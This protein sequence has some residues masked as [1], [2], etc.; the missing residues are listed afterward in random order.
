M[1]LIEG[2]SPK[3]VKVTGSQMK[4]Q[5]SARYGKHHSISLNHVPQLFTGDLQLRIRDLSLT[6]VSLTT[7]NNL[8]EFCCNVTSRSRSNNSSDLSSSISQDVRLAKMSLVH[9][10]QQC[11]DL[12]CCY[13][14]P[15]PMNVP[16]FQLGKQTKTNWSP[17]TTPGGWIIIQSP[18]IKKLSETQESSTEPVMESP[19]QSLTSE[20]SVPSVLQ[21]IAVPVINN[22]VCK[23]MYKNADYI[24]HIR[25]ILICADWKNGEFHSCE[26]DSG[27]G[28][29]NARQAMDPCWN[30]QLGK[31]LRFA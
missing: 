6:D 14:S 26:G 30:R 29:K 5:G 11:V 28:P 9:R 13:P 2:R 16:Q 18:T 4:H 24:E 21:E 1:G 20:R 22:T 27:G 8:K 25:H 19:L 23:A 10:Y 17:I 12:Y 15:S 31:K 7:S 3:P